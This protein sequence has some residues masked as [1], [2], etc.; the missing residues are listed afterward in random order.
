MKTHDMKKDYKKTLLFDFDGV[1]H[2]YVSGWQGV[3]IANDP[4]VIGINYCIDQLKEEYLIY[5]YSSRCC[6]PVGVKCIEDYMNK[7]KIYYD[8]ITNIK[9]PAYLTIDDRC[10]C[11]DG[12][13]F[14]LIDKIKEFKSWTECT[15]KMK[16][17]EIRVIK[18]LFNNINDEDDI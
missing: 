8:K 14:S 18:E 17:N 3:G 10:I 4:P 13:T 6:E 11:F 1:I 7:Y 2:S 9:P 15:T 12:D 5:I 16:P